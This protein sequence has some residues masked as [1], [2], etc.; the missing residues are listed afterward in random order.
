MT[1][2][3]PATSTAGRWA[4]VGG[5][6]SG[7]ATAW[8]LSRAGVE[9]E[10][11]EASDRLGGRS[12]SGTLGDHEITF[13]GKNIG[14]RYDLFREFARVH[15]DHPFEP[16]G[17][18]SSR[19][20]DGRLRTFDS[21]KRIRGLVGV[22][23]QM[24]PRDGL[25][26][27]GLAR[28]VKAADENR[29]LGSAEFTEIGRR[30]DDRPLAEY[31]SHRFAQGIVR[32]MTVRM[33][34]AEPDEVYLGN[35]G[36]NLGM[37][38][39]TYDQLTNGVGRL[40]DDFAAAHA[41]RTGVQVRSLLVRDG[42]VAGVRASVNGGEPEELHYDGVALAVPAGAA[43]SLIED[44]DPALAADLARVRYFP[45]AVILAEYDRPVFTP[46]VRGVVFDATEPV[47]NA[48]AY[49]VSDLNLVRYTF[50]GRAAREA[51]AAGT[52][53]ESLLELAEA[54]L[55][56]FLP[57]AAARRRDFVHRSWSHGYCAYLPRYGDFL[58]RVHSAV[59]RVGG[60]E[61]A[62]DYLRG[63]SIEACFRA[64]RDCA[65]RIATGAGAEVAGRSAGG[66]R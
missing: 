61:L 19:A 20:V 52:G 32:P 25:R 34:G 29:F 10:L 66:P 15:G 60:L 28:R 57:V 36:S 47:S 17:I 35:F 27:A 22:A 12:Q 13:G 33:N 46:E 43:A 30:S 31:F 2:T 48:G 45:A 42:R 16:F 50:S 41:V 8:M 24:T 62:G 5:G 44:A 26:F 23:R 63:A 18:N 21:T 1:A 39:D 56:R 9:A 51:L 64:A 3:A 55:G 59:G 6:M 14:R 58:E 7:M 11:L 38:L 40:I 49:G 4:V 54:Q 53:P 65:G 37:V